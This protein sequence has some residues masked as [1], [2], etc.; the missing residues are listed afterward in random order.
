MGRYNFL[1]FLVMRLMGDTRKKMRERERNH[2]R[3]IGWA[4]EREKSCEIERVGERGRGSER[5]KEYQSE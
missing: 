1:Y 5:D 3:K 4:R 2:V